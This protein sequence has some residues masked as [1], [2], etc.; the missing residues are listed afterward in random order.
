MISYVDDEHSLYPY[1]AIAYVEATFPNGKSY[2][3][4]GSVVGQNDVLTASH[5]I[6]SDADGG[7]AEKI[8]IYPG[9]DGSSKPFGPYA[10]EYVNYFE[11][12]LDNDG[13]LTRHE[14]EHDLAVIGFGSSIGEDTGWFELAQELPADSYHMTGYPGE[15]GDTSGPRMTDEVGCAKANSGADVLDFMSLDAFPGHSG[16]PLWLIE[17][18]TPF[19]AGVVST[20][21]WAAM[22]SS[23]HPQLME[24]V[25]G[26]DFLMAS[27]S[28]GC[29]DEAT[30]TA[31]Q[32]IVMDV[33]ANDV[34]KGDLMIVSVGDP[35][36][37]DADI[38]DDTLIA[39]SPRYN[40]TGTDK[41]TYTVQNE[42]GEI[43]KVFVIVKVEEPLKTYIDYHYSRA[44]S[45]YYKEI[46][47]EF[48]GVFAEEWNAKKVETAIQSLNMTIEEHLIEYGRRPDIVS[49]LF[50]Q[51]GFESSYLQGV[52]AYCNEVGYKH[53]SLADDVWTAELAKNVITHEIG[54][55][56]TDHFLVYARRPA[57]LNLIN[58]A[59]L[60]GQTINQ[61][62]NQMEACVS[63]GT[64]SVA[65]IS[66]RGS[67]RGSLEEQPPLLGLAGFL[68]ESE[69][70]GIG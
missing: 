2:R 50:S 17:E 3:G 13:L 54:M 51:E 5:V 60:C 6:F 47:Y 65:D 7:L 37:G 62:G 12:D 39:Y 26:N 41:F 45:Q 32:E 42:N 16:S 35:Q 9:M 31:D 56:V 48:D 28:F 59:E 58:E 67:D 22:T 46:G 19:V 43:N 15:Y 64:C 44:L 30:T 34:N 66:C 4:S 63:M 36:S 40:F 21:S 24:W 61:E 23:Q 68:A 38:I 69:P 55:S 33:L 8:S 49:Q 10:G 20:G 57:L 52:A 53:I 70:W 14:S 27:E 25:E 18:S 29:D 11:V 1:S